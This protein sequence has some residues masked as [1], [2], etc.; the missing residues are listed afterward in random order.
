M[1]AGAVLAAAL[2]APPASA[3]FGGRASFGEAFQPDI[4]QRDLPLMVST[5]QLEDWQRAILETLLADYMTSFNTGLEGVKERMKAAAEQAS[6][7]GNAGQGDAVLAKIMEP[8]G[9]WRK[10]KRQ[11]FEKFVSD[12]QSQL[13]PQQRELWPRFER[14]LRR[15]R[16]LH[17]GMLSGESLDVWSVLG[18]MQPT[19]VETEAIRP[20][21]DQYE[22]ALDGALTAR[23][24]RIE[25]LENDLRAA[26]Q[27]MDYDK[28][29]DIQDRIMTLRIAVRSTNDEGVEAIA[30]AM[31]ERGAE[32]R[33]QAL[34]NGY[35]DAFR[36]HP[37]L[38]LIEQAML[39]D[40]LTAEQKM[41]IEQ[42]R[43]EF[44]PVSEEANLRF[45][46]M[47]R[48]EE[49]KMP[50]RK[51]QMQ[52]ER[53]AGGAQPTPQGS[54]MSDPIVRMRV[55]R[56]QV[57]E[58]Y[59]QRLMAIL[60]PEQQP[61]LGGAGKLDPEMVRAKDPEIKQRPAT[62]GNVL[63]TTPDEDAADP[64]G[65]RARRREAQQR[66]D[67]RGAA[68]GAGDG[69]QSTPPRRPEGARDGT[70]GRD[71]GGT[72]KSGGATPPAGNP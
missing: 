72:G 30:K 40:S 49:P 24:T 66:R 21:L 18:H 15:E 50:R 16:Q 22:E 13:G 19:P 54:N 71:N 60:T 63:T 55:E 51:V 35:P 20:A 9:A 4:L 7:G 68:E 1:A 27:Q 29:A 11:L 64:R 46:T 8:W 17:E 6:K 52:K 61:L 65:D 3:Q 37:V 45:Y 44:E 38:L 53:R 23:M 33:R 32:F 70:R 31:G 5:L 43:N 10:E 58:P 12:L 42:L 48:E 67:Q 25:E 59:R 36:R 41:Q 62:A 69:K 56:E 28:G 57:G 2:I 34:V 14:A 39:L 26:M 47:L